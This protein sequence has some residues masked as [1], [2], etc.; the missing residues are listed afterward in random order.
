M[1]STITRS[2]RHA[3]LLAEAAGEVERAEAG[4]EGEVI[5]REVLASDRGCTLGPAAPPDARRERAL[6]VPE[7]SSSIVDEATNDRRRLS[8]LERSRGESKS[9]VHGAKRLRELGVGERRSGAD[10]RHATTPSL[11]ALRV[12]RAQGRGRDTCIP[13]L[14]DWPV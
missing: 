4:G 2:S 14:A 3:N 8:L 9:R 10:A 11:S 12:A 6:I 13:G 1:Y 7:K 5:E